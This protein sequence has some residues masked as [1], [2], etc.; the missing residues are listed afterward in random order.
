MRKYTWKPDC[1]VP[2]ADL[3][4]IKLSYWGFDNKPH[5]GIIIIHKNL[6]PEVI[7]IFKTLY[8]HHF[9]I[10]RMQPMY[11]YKGDDDKS[12]LANNTVGFNCRHQTDFP[13][14]F[15]PHS[16]GGAID[17]NPLINPYVNN[18][19]VEPKAATKYAPRNIP[20]KGKVVPKGIVLQTFSKYG[21]SWGGNWDKR[22][23]K[24]YQ[25]FEKYPLKH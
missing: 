13:K 12:M 15:S 2:L 25:H 11:L 18:G 19:K 24:D 22:G 20:A 17:I 1:P 8:Q 21:W 4:Y 6:A 5:L 16:Y 10:Q 14:L 3:A 23:I 9:P 7:Q